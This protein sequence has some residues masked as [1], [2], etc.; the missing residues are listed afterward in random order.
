M[1]SEAGSTEREPLD[2]LETPQKPDDARRKVDEL[3][4]E[5]V[6]TPDPGAEPVVDPSADQQSEDEPSGANEPPD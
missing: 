5:H 4:D 1:S 2:P 6:S 3:E